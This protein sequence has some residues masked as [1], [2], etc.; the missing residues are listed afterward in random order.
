MNTYEN[1]NF[2]YKKKKMH[3]IIKNSWRFS[4]ARQNIENHLFRPHELLSQEH[5]LYEELTKNRKDSIFYKELYLCKSEEAYHKSLLFLLDQKAKNLNVLWGLDPYRLFFTLGYLMAHSLDSREY[6]P[7]WIDCKFLQNSESFFKTTNIY[8]CIAICVGVENNITQIKHNL[9]RQNWLLLI[10]ASFL[11]EKKQRIFFEK[12]SEICQNLSG[13]IK[14]IIVTTCPCSTAESILKKAVFW[15]T[16]HEL[17]TLPTPWPSFKNWAEHIEVLIEHSNFSS[18]LI[19]WKGIF[20]RWNGPWN[21]IYLQHLLIR[22]YKKWSEKKAP[23]LIPK[24]QVEE[25]I[26]IC[27]NLPAPDKNDDWIEIQN[28]K[29]S[30]QDK[31]HILLPN[32]L[33][34]EWEQWKTQKQESFVVAD[35]AESW[36]TFVGDTRK[37]N[38]ITLPTVISKILE[39]LIS[40]IFIYNPENIEEAINKIRFL[41]FSQGKLNLTSYFLP[42]YDLNYFFYAFCQIF[43]WKIKPSTMLLGRIDCPSKIEELQPTNSIKIRRCNEFNTAL[44]SILF[45]YPNL[46]TLIISAEQQADIENFSHSEIDVKKTLEG[47]IFVSNFGH[48]NIY[49][50]A[51]L[52]DLL[53]KE[54]IDHSNSIYKL[55]FILNSL[56]RKVTSKPIGLLFEIGFGGSMAFICCWMATLTVSGILGVDT[57][58]LPVIASLMIICLS[59]FQCYNRHKKY[60]TLKQMY[61]YTRWLY[62]HTLKSVSYMRASMFSFLTT[63]IIARIYLE[64]S[65][66]IREFELVLAT[67]IFTIVIFA[68]PLAALLLIQNIVYCKIARG[69]GLNKSGMKFL[70]NK[71][72]MEEHR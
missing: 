50:V 43:G 2:L 27:R 13:N 48:L 28:C 12:I 22:I 58:I 15:A 41:R 71:A 60:K 6:V 39:K 9:N 51:T 68:M 65:D 72:R 16:S 55:E 14:L 40:E 10:D 1:L 66:I 62:R 3:Q 67:S 25:L 20:D 54:I 34:F 5:N 53:H 36:I 19:A 57:A 63:P 30:F 35:V 42:P 7:I 46:Q 8:D 31:N 45:N 17:L 47:Y 26:Q 49:L 11:E 29:F 56:E 33:L 24:S 59:F 38:L 32:L 64:T 4:I 44:H 18:A 37:D 21:T 52:Q 69:N 70:W 23:F 61:Q